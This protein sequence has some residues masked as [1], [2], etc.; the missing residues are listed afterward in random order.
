MKTIA[1]KPMRWVLVV[2][3]LSAAS[4]ASAEPTKKPAL[5]RQKYLLLDSRIVD[6]VSGAQLKVGTVAKHPANPLFGRDKPWEIN[7]DNLY[8]NVAYDDQAKLYKCWHHNDYP[9]NVLCFAQ[10]KDGLKWDKPALGLVD[11]KGSK[12]NNILFAGGGHGVGV[13]LDHHETDPARRFKMFYSARPSP[14]VVALATRFSPD[15]IHWGDE[16]V[17]SSRPRGDTHNNALWAPTLGKYVGFSRG[18]EEPV[19]RVVNRVESTNFLDWTDPVVV[20]SGIRRRQTYSMPVF[21]YGGVYLGLPTILRYDKGSRVHVELA[22]SPD[23]VNW[24][25]IQADTPLIP[26]SQTKGDYDWGIVYPNVA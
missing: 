5:E 20:L 14:R 10:S 2:G 26:G 1:R 16:N 11:Y 3:L 6:T 15:G 9:H 13:F 24:H 12:E 8:P 7:L 25:R 17:S 18:W 4:I 19:Q 22:W 23:T 21:Y